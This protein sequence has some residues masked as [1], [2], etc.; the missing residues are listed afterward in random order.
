[1]LGA[2]STPVDVVDERLGII[3]V[4]Y[5]RMPL[6]TSDESECDGIRDEGQLN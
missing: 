4:Q 5:L 1:M 2:D 3:C 6:K